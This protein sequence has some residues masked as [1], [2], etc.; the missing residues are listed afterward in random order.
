MIFDTHTHYDDEAFDSDREELLSSLPGQGIGTVVQVC[1]S[2]ESLERTAAMVRRWPHV[3]GAVGVH[4]DYAPEVTDEV[5]EKIRLLCREEKILAVGEIGLDYYWHKQEEEHRNQQLVFRKQLTL[6]REE[7]LPFMVH[8]RE[9]AADTLQI[10]REF[11]AGGMP[12]GIIHCFPYSWEIAREY[13]NMGLFLGI[14]GVVTY[15]NARRLVEVVEKA[16]LSQLVLETDCPYLA[17]VPNR[18]KRNS[19]LNLPFVAERI[20]QIRGISAEE[21]AAVTEENAKRLLR[22]SQ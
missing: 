2:V 11:M 22:V 15:K 8:S 18:G 5:L 10:V 14:G 21:V 3:Y 1:A 13:L 9:A 7:G 20:A 19:S 12:G 16:P 17:P 6:A 4:P